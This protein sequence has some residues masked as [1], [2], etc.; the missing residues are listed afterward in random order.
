V[1]NVDELDLAVAPERVDHRIER[2]SDDSVAAFDAGLR[3]HLPHDVSNFLRHWKL[4][5]AAQAFRA[6]AKFFE[7]SDIRVENII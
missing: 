7:S 2:V 1:A 4:H 3:Q 5:T 6:L